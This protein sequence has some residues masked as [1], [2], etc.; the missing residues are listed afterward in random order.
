MRSPS[1]DVAVT[2]APATKLLTNDTEP[3]NV[4]DDE[5]D[6]AATLLPLLLMLLLV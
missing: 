6:A 4:D 5:D 3:E 1:D 2:C